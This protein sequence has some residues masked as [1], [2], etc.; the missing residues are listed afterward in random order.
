MKTLSHSCAFQLRD[1]LALAITSSRKN[2][3]DFGGHVD[4][5]WSPWHLCSEYACRISLQIFHR[6]MQPAPAKLDRRHDQIMHK[7]LAFTVTPATEDMTGS[8]CWVWGEPTTL[9]PCKT[10][11]PPPPTQLAP[12]MREAHNKFGRHRD[13]DLHEVLPSSWGISTEA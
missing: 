1:F 11:V 8:K 2:T 10:R 13:Y 12:K 5:K 6:T 9:V 4:D 7:V 3:A